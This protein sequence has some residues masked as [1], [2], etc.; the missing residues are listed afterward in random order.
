MISK[1]RLS[2][3]ALGG[4]AAIL[5]VG[6]LA[7]PPTD[8]PSCAE[9]VRRGFRPIANDRAQRFL[10]KVQPFTADCR[11]PE[12][13][14]EASTTPWVD[15]SNYWGTADAA[16]KSGLGLIPRFNRNGRGIDGALLDLEYQRIEL[17]KFNLFENY[18]FVY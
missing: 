14:R 9:Q 11:G 13:V 7:F 18:T 17:I 15:W 3:V 4:L 12:R 5:A 16:S 1:K 2:L 6:F 10:G 8:L